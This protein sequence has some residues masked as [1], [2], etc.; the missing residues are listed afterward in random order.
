M[1]RVLA[2]LAL[3]ALVLSG[4]S[5]PGTPH[6]THDVTILNRGNGAEI[7]SLD[8]HYITGN[9]EA[10]VIGD[11]LI[12]LTTEGPDGSPIPGAAERWE[13]SPDGKTWTFHLRNHVW[14]DG[15]PVTAQDFVFAW[16]RIL[17]PARGAQYAYYLW[18]VKNAHD[19]N[20][21][22]LPGTAL[23]ITAKDD[24]TLVV[25]LEQPAPYLPE[26]LMHQ[27]T[28]PVPRHKVLALGDAWSKPE[29][30]VANGPYIP[31]EWIPND[32]VTLVKNPHFYDAAHVRIETV[33]YYPTV[34]G[35]SALK[36]MLAGEL[37]TQEPL[38]I[39]EIDW[40]RKNM[41]RQL[42]LHENL[43]N[44][45]LIFNLTR[46][47]FDD[48]R[49][50][51]AMSLAYDR[52]DITFKILKLGDPPAYAFVPPGTANYPAGAHL[53]F[54]SMPYSERVKKA[55]ALMAEMG[56]GPA[57]HFQTTYMITSNPDNKRVAAAVQRQMKQI[58]VD[59]EI[60]TIDAQN[61]YKTLGL[62]DFDLAGAAWIGDFNDASTFLDLLHTGS[63][64]NYGA[65][66]NPKFDKLYETSLQQTDILKRGELMKQAEQ[67]ALDDDAVIPT[68]FRLT[69]DLVQ[70]YV[71][72]WKVGANVR[73]FHRTRWLWIDPKAVGR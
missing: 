27:T 52:E 14:S 5:K 11:C 61:F 18:L 7:S 25:Q 60:V 29:N 66:S 10:Y 42:D 72:G 67:V 35:S 3:I 59:I 71:K 49:L 40:L 41:S 53:Y 1:H 50:R 33:N 56:Y 12:G 36:Q 26:W 51:D 24:K 30:Y 62:R 43:S 64:Q 47:K 63:T 58:Y 16:R 21:G 39:T 54:Q 48:H 28:Y 8:P 20:V 55:Q 68:R 9:W 57:R 2:P 31:R 69:Q 37:D 65:Y 34:D 44:S 19:V 45:Y 38:P 6:L 70:P 46:H 4:C 32:H 15:V 22:K 13:V 17:E 73:N 23:G